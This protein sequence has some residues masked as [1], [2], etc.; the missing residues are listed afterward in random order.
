V[1]GTVGAVVLV[2][3][4]LSILVAVLAGKFIASGDREPPPID[5]RSARRIYHLDEMFPGHEA[6]ADRSER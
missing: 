5:K 6:D 3:A 1:V 4:I 2:W